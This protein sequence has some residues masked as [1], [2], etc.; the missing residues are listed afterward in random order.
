M[1]KPAPPTATN[2]PGPLSGYRIVDLTRVLSGP[3]ATMILG[4]LGADVIKIETPDGDS[5][6]TQ[7]AAPAGMSWYFA[8]FNRNKRSIVLDLK[9]DAGRAALTQLIAGADALVEN[10]RPG[11]LARLGF[12]PAR[13]Q[14]IR[15]GLVTAAISGFGADGPYKDRPAFDFIAQA[16]SGFMSTNGQA[17]GP[18]MRTGMPV[19]DMVAGIYT[20]LAVTA[21]LLGRERH[22]SPA[23]PMGEHVDVSMTNSAIS[24][25]AY[26]ASNYFATG[27]LPPRTG[28]DHPI[29]APYGLFQAQDQKIAIAPP[30]DT[31]FGRLMD[32]LDLG[33]A[34]SNPEFAT[35]PLRIKNRT[36]LNGLVELRL[37]TKP[38]A[39]WVEHLNRAGVPCGPVNTLEQVFA[40]PQIRHQQMALDVPHPGRGTIRMV[41]FPMKFRHAPCQIR[42]PAPELGQHTTEI[43]AL[44]GR[45]AND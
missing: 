1:T 42:R 8:G 18:P 40:D 33:A 39:Y 23:D 37:A 28:N 7:G 45:P 36:A 20:A 16:M 3:F 13:L 22:A 35:N 2:R 38:A 11:V 10:F 6:R 44:L 25:F 26:L 32:A 12:D 14:A 27:Q 41:G 19:T 17:D 24:M 31:F 15:P 43:L 9:S 29:A 21:A 34:K 30:D 4:D 5:V